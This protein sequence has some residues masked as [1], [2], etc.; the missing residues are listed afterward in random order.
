MQEQKLAQRVL[1]IEESPSGAAAER[2]RRLRAEGHRILSLTVG[3]PDFDTPR[4]VKDAA[5]AAIEAGDTKYTSG[6]GT[7][8]LRNAVLDRVERRTGQR[9]TE[10]QL[11]VG[12]GG[13]QVI[14]TALQATL[15][16]GDEVIIPAPY[17]V[18]Y[19]DMVRANEGEPVI[20]ETREEHGFRLQPEQLRAALTERTRWIILNAPSNPT[21]AVYSA[22][23]L[24]ALADVLA[25]HPGVE[26]LTDEIYD[27]IHYG[28]DR[29]VSIVEAAPELRERVFVVNGVSK[30]YAMTGWRVGYGVGPEYLVREINKLHS[31]TTSSTA[32]ISQAAAAEALAGDQSAVPAMVE[33]YR[34]RRDLVVAGINSIAGLSTLSPDGAFYLYVNC[35]ELLGRTTPSG[36]LLANDEDVALYLLEEA[37]VAVVHGGA[38]G[39][40]PF[41]RISFA[42]DEA[43]LTEAVEAL[44]GAVA[45]LV[46]TADAREGSR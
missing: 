1:R 10:A 46:R 25:D 23:Q 34:S 41:F 5:I 18:S 27:E 24:R 12:V 11:A 44:R 43:T 6:N 8:A 3:E 29:V 13:K 16:A 22:E 17:W 28:E 9:Y 7:A 30:T 21:G 2:V 4:N 20:L 14:F 19:P 38:Y 36:S 39:L 31:Q 26:V 33:V 15:D 35:A 32:S 40:S 45:K 37:K 42:T